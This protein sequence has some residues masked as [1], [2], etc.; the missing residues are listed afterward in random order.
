MHQKLKEI[1]EDVLE[2]EKE[3]SLRPLSYIDTTHN[4]DKFW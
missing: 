3:V 1:N 2:V 4:C